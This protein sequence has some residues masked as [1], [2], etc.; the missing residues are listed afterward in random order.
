MGSE[1]AADA[2]L[3][4]SQ[5]AAGRAA[6]SFEFGANHRHNKNPHSSA[7]VAALIISLDYDLIFLLANAYRFYRY[8]S[9]GV[10]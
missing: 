3:T 10:P 6:G 7:A 2:Q 9:A 5:L 4:R 1:S 8:R